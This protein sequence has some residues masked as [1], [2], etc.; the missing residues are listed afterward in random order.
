[1]PKRTPK[2]K[3]A[4]TPFQKRMAEL[5]RNGSDENDIGSSDAPDAGDEIKTASMVDVGL[6]VSG[7]KYLVADW[8]PYG[9]VTMLVAEPGV[10]KSA[11]ALYGIVRS[12]ITG[13][14]WFSG[15]RGPKE[16]GFVL[17]CDT[18]GSAAINFQ[19]IK[20]W[21]L[22]AERILV[23]FDDPLRAVVLTGEEDLERLETLAD[24]LKPKVIVID[25]LRGGHVDDE[26]N[27][28]VGKVLQ[29]LTAIAERTKTAIL[30]IH[31]TRKLQV[32]EELT[33][34]SSRGSNA[35]L[36]MVRSQIGIDKPDKDG[37]WCRI[38]M[39]KENLGIKPAP[40]GMRIH[41]KGI[42]FGVAPTKPRNETRRDRAE[43]WLQK[44]M[45]PGRWLSAKTLADNAEGDGLSKNALSRARDVLG[46]LQPD[47]VRKTKTGWEWRLPVPREKK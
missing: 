21:N 41:S 34:N 27:S 7:I 28:R 30:L 11:F 2:E 5:K 9:M 14:D 12:I 26:N 37:E 29:R 36:A 35:I 16:P 6:L 20:D 33:A 19:R 47:N 25:S 18:E 42:E 4:L 24:H 17:W 38:Q 32:D 15:T 3:K 39:L 8:I 46:I 44:N 22:P 13:C 23:P 1:M 40:I 43:D 31:H 10:G 45:K